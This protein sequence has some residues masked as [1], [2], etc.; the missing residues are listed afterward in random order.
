MIGPEVVPAAESA[1]RSVV[2]LLSVACLVALAAKRLRMPYTVALVVVGIA[3]GFFHVLHPVEIS[4]EVLMLVFLPPLLFEG[5]LAMDLKTLRDR[6]L[7]VAFLAL[8]VTILSFLAT[9]WLVQTVTGYAWPVA[10]LVAAMLAPTDPVSV[11]ATFRS[12]GVPRPVA[13]LVEGESVF[14]D[15]I[16]VVIFLVIA[17]YL[18][19][20]SMGPLD[21]AGLFIFEVVGGVVVGGVAAYLI[22]RLLAR[23]EDHLI[24]VVIS[25]SLAY[26][27]Y[28]LAEAAHVSGVMAVV[29]A[30]L[31]IGN[32][33]KVHSMSA[34]T[35]LA[36]TAFWE[37]AA[38]IANSLVFLLM[39]IALQSTDLVPAAA[40][41]VLIFIGMN[42]ARLVIIWLA[43]QSLVLMGRPF[44]PKWR[45]VVAWSGLR[46]S[47]PIALVLG[48]TPETW[49]GSG[50]PARQE[51]LTLVSGVVLLSLL[52][53]GLSIG[54]LLRKMGILT[55]TEGEDDFDRATA[56]RIS[57]AA[58]ARR[59]EEMES[60]GEVPTALQ[61]AFAEE[62]KE[63][64]ERG[65][66]G[67]AALLLAHPELAR[68]RA[69][70]IRRS[71]LHA[72][73]AALDMALHHGQIST[74]V[75][76][77]GNRRIDDAL[78][79]LGEGR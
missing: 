52:V 31:I 4:R 10:L 21:V 55:R 8:P 51:L 23:I 67:Q 29:A 41:F 1:T 2:E 25:L 39:G 27:V 42:I 63:R 26:G 70:E 50:H 71:L 72:E 11:L 14:N 57:A 43:G 20:A 19:G 40:R 53:Q 62:I 30:G 16:G 35:R 47:I 38:Y 74:P 17:R 45:L 49:V 36:L 66:Q 3:V 56:D 68:A 28:L 78:I 76:E 6:W 48:I 65:M 33:A 46:G 22:H 59:L 79:E 75:V 44:P 64:D 5:T 34:R 58:A 61:A 13:M 54:P 24:E 37:V 15:G 60:T 7:E 32:F 77:E 69:D 12:L 9:G 18:G 73:R